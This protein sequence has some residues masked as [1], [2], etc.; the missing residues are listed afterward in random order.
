[1]KVRKILKCV[2]IFKKINWK[3]NLLIGIKMMVKKFFV[4]WICPL[5]NS[6]S[7][8]MINKNI[9]L[10]FKHLYVEHSK[11]LLRKKEALGKR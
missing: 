1:M 5:Q 4:N 6:F 11:E 2:S 7:F 9:I 8:N 3:Y 10:K